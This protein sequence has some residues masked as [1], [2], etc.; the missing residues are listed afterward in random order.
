MK[1]LLL[2]YLL[3][4]DKSCLF[5]LWFNVHVN[6]FSVMSGCSLHLLGVIQCI[7]ERMCPAQGHNQAPKAE[8][9]TENLIQSLKLYH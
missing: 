4:G 3:L 8:F 2:E 6:N 1:I 7:Y 9:E 5:V